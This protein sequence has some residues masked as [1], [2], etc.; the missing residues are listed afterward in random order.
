VAHDGRVTA[1]GAPRGETRGD[2]ARAALLDA[3]ERL[4][5]ERGIEAVSLRDVC[6]AAGQRNHSAAQYHFGDRR[7]LV[8][9]V[10]ERRMRIVGERRHAMLDALTASGDAT[11]ITGIVAAIVVPLTEVVAESDAWYG[12]FLARSRWDTL[13]AEVT[14]DLPVVAS[15]RRALDLLAAATDLPAPRRRARFDQLANLLIG[16]VAGW[17]WQGQRGAP[18]LALVELQS[19]LISTLSAV[20][21]A[22]TLRRTP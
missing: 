4:F 13:A 18:R 12:R 21:H 11:D 16:T 8:A 9:A 17:E 1:Q 22:P 14:A 5:A 3:A 10:F 20:V 6:A 2:V 19:E 7:N 15:Y